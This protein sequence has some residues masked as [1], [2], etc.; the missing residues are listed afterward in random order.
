MAKNLCYCIEEDCPAEHGILNPGPQEFPPGH[1]VDCGMNVPFGDII[2]DIC[3]NQWQTYQN[4]GPQHGEMART[5]GEKPASQTRPL[6]DLR[7]SEDKNSG[8]QERRD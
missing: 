5:S 7:P 6:F 4:L 8:L 2:C 1:C 3:K